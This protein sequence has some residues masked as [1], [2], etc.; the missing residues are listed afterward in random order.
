MASFLL[1]NAIFSRFHQN[2][3]FLPTSPLFSKSG[4]LGKKCTFWWISHFSGNRSSKGS[5][6]LV[7]LKHFRHWPGMWF[8]LKKYFLKMRKRTFL[9]NS[10]FFS[11][12]R[13]YFLKLQKNDFLMVWG[14]SKALLPATQK[15]TAREMARNRSKSG[16]STKWWENA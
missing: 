7:F 1:Q 2:E 5:I 15:V 16:F 10:N 13:K 6:S 3:H 12:I 9:L 11:K 14:P 4:F 8:L